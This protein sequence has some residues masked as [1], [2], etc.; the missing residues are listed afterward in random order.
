FAYAL[1]QQ[2]VGVP[3]LAALARTVSEGEG[4]VCPLLDARKGEIY[5]ALFRRA[6]D[7]QLVQILPDQV[8][9]PQQ[10]LAR[11]TEPCLFVGDGATAY[12]ELIERTCGALA[13][14]LPITT[15]HPRGAIIA[16]MAW[17]RLQVGGAD[18]LQSLVPVYVRAPEAVVKRGIIV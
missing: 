8:L 3:T 7:G 4:L 12:R 9:L 17:E 1:G 18:D 14:I 13:E 5:A 15:H 11:I 2:V 10:F 6:Y 16:R